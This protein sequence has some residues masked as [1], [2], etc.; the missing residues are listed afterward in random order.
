MKKL[1]SLALVL[2][3]CLTLV[4]C[5]QS[6]V[7]AP[8]LYAAAEKLATAQS[9]RITVSRT[10]GVKPSTHTYQI[11]RNDGITY[12]LTEFE[13]GN[14]P[15]KSTM[16]YE[17]NVCYYTHPTE[18]D[19][20]HKTIYE[21]GYQLEDIV[22]GTDLQGDMN[23]FFDA[24]LATSPECTQKD[25]MTVASKKL[26]KDDYIS[27][28]YKVF[29][30]IDEEYINLGK[31][32][33]S[34]SVDSEGYLREIDLRTGLLRAGASITF[35]FDKINEIPSL[36]AP[37]FAKNFSANMGFGNPT[38]DS[39]FTNI[40]VIKGDVGTTYEYNPMII[41]QWDGLCFNGFSTDKEEEYVIPVYEI[42]EEVDG[43]PVKYISF[44]YTPFT[45]IRVERVVIPKGIKFLPA[46]EDDNKIDTVLFFYDAEENVEKNFGTW[47]EPAE[48][49]YCYKAAYYAGEWEYVD[50]IP[51]PL[52]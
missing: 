18:G 37:D 50:G 16:Y 13:G 24:F 15:Y 12:M 25:G 36:E 20:Q 43:I 45:T 33:V 48:D 30:F 40:G 7:P 3:F 4:A 27:L 44:M 17:G 31:G 5:G 35:T 21:D 2:S 32:T 28:A 10:D 47:E 39:P 29:T 49:I 52:K 6:D 19:T 42:P 1:L 8:D 46:S 14:S 41:D 38:I 9:Y 22:C 51:T 11:V 26:S 23:G 34:V